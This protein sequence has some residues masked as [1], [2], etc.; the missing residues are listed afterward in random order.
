M[1]D[2]KS[3]F[4]QGGLTSTD[5]EKQFNDK[6]W[7]KGAIRESQ[8]KRTFTQMGNRFT[9]PKHY[10]D[11]IEKERHFPIFHP[12]NQL[13][14]GIAAN[15]A[16]LLT[17]RFFATTADGEALIDLSKKVATSEFDSVVDA[18]AAL[19]AFNTANGTTGG[20]ITSG[21][22]S[23]FN[24]DADYTVL[25]DAY[26][27][28]DEE[29]GNVNAVN[30]KSVVVKGSVAE[31]G[32]HMKF[33]QRSIDMDSRT[34][35]LAQKAKDLGEAK[36]DLYEA[37]L[38]SDLLT[39]AQLNT[40]YASETATSMTELKS[41]DVLTFADLRLMEQ[42]L[43]RA[44]V[45][46][47]TKVISGSTKIGTKVVGKAYYVYVGQEMYP[48]LQD[49]DHMGVKVWEPVESYMDAANSNIAEGEIGRIGG[50]R[51]I[52]V[53]NMQKYAAAGA[54][55]STDTGADTDNRF[56]RNDK[57]DVFPVL[58]IGSDSFGTVGFEG[59]SARIKTAMPKPDAHNDPFGKNGSMSISWYFGT[60]IYR[61]ERIRQIV[62][63]AK[64]A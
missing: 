50:F 34:G 58:F 7:S 54:T 41:D 12:M 37:Q 46:K 3:K 10:G 24:G 35:I 61:P 28:L 48:T 2:L 38:Q 63:T 31:F 29:G 1:A 14:N 43:K 15:T 11:V 42:E 44:L 4:N 17:S 30:A 57:Y 20:K 27:T 51:F 45:P 62:C 18:Q 40:T 19:D 55:V 47:D 5:L 8:R 32:L 36:G 26:P 21:A 9:Q 6:F 53:A 23:L 60:L 16:K 64:V 13:D 59:D 22:G 25:T 33:T 56:Q 52:E 49:M 39:A